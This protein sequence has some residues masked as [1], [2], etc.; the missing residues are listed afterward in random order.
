V[1]DICAT[2]TCIARNYLKTKVLYL[3]VATD[4]KPISLCFI[5]LRN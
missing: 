2:H 4:S 1:N 3:H 5:F